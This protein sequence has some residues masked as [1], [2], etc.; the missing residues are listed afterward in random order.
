MGASAIRTGLQRFA[1]RR[2]ERRLRLCETVQM[3]ER[4]FV[5]VLQYE[6]QRFLVGATPNSISVLARLASSRSE[7]FA[8]M[9]SD[10]YEMGAVDRRRLQ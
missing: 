8:A 4:R 5:A 2:P 7:N 10:F 9:L 6:D 3:G 1:V